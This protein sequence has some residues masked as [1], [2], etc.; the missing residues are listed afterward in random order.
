MKPQTSEYQITQPR[1]NFSIDCSK[2]KINVHSNTSL[3]V[4]RIIGQ[5]MLSCLQSLSLLLLTKTRTK[6][7]AKDYKPLGSDNLKDFFLLVFLSLK[8]YDSKP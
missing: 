6:I 8:K 4:I 1:G 7:A 3:F 2:T 5:L